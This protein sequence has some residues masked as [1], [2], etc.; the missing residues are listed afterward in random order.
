MNLYSSKMFISVILSAAP[1]RFFQ[2]E[3]LKREVEGPRGF[4]FYS[5][6]IR[7]FSQYPRAHAFLPCAEPLAGK[8]CM[9]WG[10][11]ESNG[12]SLSRM[13][14]RTCGSWRACRLDVIVAV[15]EKAGKPLGREAL[16]RT[17]LVQGG[18]SREIR[19][20]IHGYLRDGSLTLYRGDKIGL[21]EWNTTSQ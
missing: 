8:P 5:Y 18:S 2:T 17:L 1:P 19:Y 20:C 16:M 3:I 4:F 13:L 14:I 7:E 10:F 12:L 11:R 9:P 6:C 21:P 15:L